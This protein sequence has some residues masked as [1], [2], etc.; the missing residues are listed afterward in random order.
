M[1][2]KPQKKREKEYE[3]ECLDCGRTKKADED[4]FAICWCNKEKTTVLRPCGI[5]EEP[6]QTA[7]I[8]DSCAEQSEFD[9]FTHP[10]EIW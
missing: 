6:I 8:C 7:E 9:S 3:A 5:C 2:G 4:G 10:N 1:Q